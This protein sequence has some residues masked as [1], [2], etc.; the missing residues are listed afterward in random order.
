VAK[1]SEK[2]TPVVRESPVSKEV[3][4]GGSPDAVKEKSDSKSPAWQ[5]RWIDRPHPDW[6]W[7]IG[8][9]R[10]A[11]LMKS[12]QDFEGMTWAEIQSA[13]GGKSHGTN[14]H[15]I[16]VT[17]L[18]NAAQGRLKELGFEEEDE[19]FSLRLTNTLRLYGIREDRTLRF[20][21]HDTHHGTKRACY[22]PKR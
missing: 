20:I 18:T 7:N 11:S 12:L 19:V 13:A 22:P 10:W 3:R 5:F 4:A 17:K 6:G 2:R 9:N 16:V 1:P 14:S 8:A 15:S 21:W